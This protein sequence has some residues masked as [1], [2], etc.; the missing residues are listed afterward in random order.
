MGVFFLFCFESF[1][2]PSRLWWRQWQQR[3]REL[4]VCCLG[5]CSHASENGYV[6]LSWEHEHVCTY[7]SRG[8]D[9]VCS[10]LLLPMGEFIGLFPGVEFSGKFLSVT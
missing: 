1:P 8:S 2:P 7:M 5:V 6:G 9:G 4:C 10:Y 3:T